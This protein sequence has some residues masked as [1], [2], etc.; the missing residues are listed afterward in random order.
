MRFHYLIIGLLFCGLSPIAFAN[1]PAGT[2][3]NIDNWGNEVCVSSSGGN[4]TIR[5]NAPGCP[6]GTVPEFDSWGNATCVS[7]DQP[8]RR[9]Y[10]TS[11][12]CPGGTIPDFDDYGNQV[13]KPF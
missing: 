9:Y 7:I 6:G 1:C 8:S 5:G 4:R 11:K 2:F 10:D 13:C 12:G 3:P